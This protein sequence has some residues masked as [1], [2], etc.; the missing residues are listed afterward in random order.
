MR[1]LI[2][3]IV[4]LIMVIIFLNILPW[5]ISIPMPLHILM[6]CLSVINSCLAG[7]SVAEWSRIVKDRHYT[8]FLWY[9]RMGMFESALLIEPKIANKYWLLD[10][11]PGNWI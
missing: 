8:R 4:G 6:I 5:V 10:K 1:M 2:I 3:S 7:R 11:L 9:R